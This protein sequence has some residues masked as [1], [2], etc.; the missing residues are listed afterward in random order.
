MLKLGRSHKEYRLPEHL[1]RIWSHE[2]HWDRPRPEWREHCV[3][4]LE[5][6]ARNRGLIIVS[7]SP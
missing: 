5:M 1:Q 2:C 7:R 6:C 3:L 4:E